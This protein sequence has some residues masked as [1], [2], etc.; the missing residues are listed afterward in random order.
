M[1]QPLVAPVH[2]AILSRLTAQDQD[3][4]HIGFLP[5]VSFCTPSPCLSFLGPSLLVLLD[6]CWGSCRQY[7]PRT[8][9]FRCLVCMVRTPF[10]FFRR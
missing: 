4:V 9:F 6:Q 10:L 3:Q 7:M 5:L 2:S 8:N 1:F